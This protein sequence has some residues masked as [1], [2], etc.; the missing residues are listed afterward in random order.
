MEKNELN[1]TTD[2]LCD[3]WMVVCKEANSENI[4]IDT[5]DEYHV[6]LVELM[7]AL[8]KVLFFKLQNEIPSFT[9]ILAIMTEFGQSEPIESIVSLLKVYNPIFDNVHNLNEAA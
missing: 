3:L 6:S 9:K 8:E 1:I 2:F 5:E 4:D 7:A